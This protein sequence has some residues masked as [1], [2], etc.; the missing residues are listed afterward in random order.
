MY[1]WMTIIALGFWS[2]IV[3]EVQAQPIYRWEDHNGTIHYSQQPPQQEFSQQL[4]T[5]LDTGLPQ[6]FSSDTRR[7]SAALPFSRG[8]LWRIEEAAPK[9][10]R[11]PPSY[12]FGTIHS[13]DPRLAPLPKA[14]HEALAQSNTFC[15]ELLPDLATTLTLTKSMLYEDDHSLVEVIGQKLFEQIA[16][17]MLRRGIPTQALLKLKPWA[18]YMTLS[19]PPAQ[20]GRILDLILYEKARD[21]GKT[22]CGIETAEEQ[23]AVFEQTPL[24]DQIALLQELASDPQAVDLQIQKMIPLYLQQDLAGLAALTTAE[25]DAS[26]KAFLKRLLDERNQR[27]LDRVLPLLSKKTAFI[28]VGALHLPG[29]MGLLQLLTDHGYIVSPLR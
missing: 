25:T 8:L 4:D 22:L 19:T 23:V 15:M 1:G 17:L 11:S 6:P 29:Q 2:F 28:A 5:G 20:T 10:K 14:V 3:A 27:M 21:D 16:P 26:A 7:E 18:A 13:E 24:S 12:L 9:G